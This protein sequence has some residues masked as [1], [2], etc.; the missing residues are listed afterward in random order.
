MLSPFRELYI[1]KRHIHRY[2]STALSK[3]PTL[4][5]HT[6]LLPIKTLE[7]PFELEVKPTPFT[8]ELSFA[9]CNVLGMGWRTSSHRRS[10]HIPTPAAV[11]IG[12]V[13]LRGDLGVD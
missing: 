5:G 4:S 13:V 3:N 9:R 2:E 10:V 6:S 11:S 12:F 7:P 8:K 1:V